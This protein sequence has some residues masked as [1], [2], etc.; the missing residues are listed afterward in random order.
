MVFRDRKG[1]KNSKGPE[2]EKPARLP[3]WREALADD[4]NSCE[5]CPVFVSL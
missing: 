4:L 2:K 3:A 5:D 1:R